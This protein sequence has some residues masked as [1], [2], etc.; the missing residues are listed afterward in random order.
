MSDHGPADPSLMLFPLPLRAGKRDPAER[1]PDSREKSA[2]NI[3][4]HDVV[5]C[6]VRKEVRQL[7]KHARHPFQRAT[8]WGQKW[9]CR[10]ASAKAS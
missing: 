8:M 10:V 3:N 5:A 6:S 1:N 2:T 4:Q 7:R 9:G